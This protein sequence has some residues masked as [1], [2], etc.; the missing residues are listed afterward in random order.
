MNII[1]KLYALVIR[2]R[3]P[4]EP[5]GTFH[6]PSGRAPQHVRC[7][8]CGRLPHQWEDGFMIYGVPTCED[9]FWEMDD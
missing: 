3:R 8:R 4:R 1:R 5:L 7:G 2:L 6:A 9:C